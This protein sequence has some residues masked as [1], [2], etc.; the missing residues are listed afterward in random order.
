[1]SAKDEQLKQL[2]ARLDSMK[3]TLEEALVER[4]RQH[5][6]LRSYESQINDLEMELRN[7][8]D[9]DALQDLEKRVLSLTKERDLLQLQVNDLTRSMEELKDSIN[10]GRNSEMERVGRERD[11]ARE[12]IASLSR[13]L[14]EARERQSDKATVTDDTKE[15]L[16]RRASKIE[17]RSVSLD[18]GEA[19]KI[20]VDEEIWGWN[21]EDAQLDSEQAMAS[22]ILIPNTEIQLRAKVDDLQDQV[23]D[24]ERERARM[25]EENKAAQLRNAKMLK[26]LKEYKA[27]AESLQQQLKIQ[28]TAADFYGLDSAIEEELKSQI[29][30]LEKNLTRLRRRGGTRLPRRRR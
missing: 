1:M 29:G 19:E 20:N 18:V 30:K 12:T 21:T 14:E 23:K 17:E 3:E 26:K 28:K 8:T 10:R 13:A 7:S 11:E 6:L 4:D 25:G 15:S 9:L 22:T 24:L 27:Q 2:N 16:E 5:S